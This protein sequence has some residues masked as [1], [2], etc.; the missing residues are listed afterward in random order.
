MSFCDSPS[1]D[2]DRFDR[3]KR[4]TGF[5]HTAIDALWDELPDVADKRVLAVRGFANIVRQHVA[6]QRV[7]A[8]CQL[9]L[10]VM[11]LVRPTYE[12]LVRAVW[13]LNGAENVWI[14]GFFSPKE[15][16]IISDAE[17]RKG[18]DVDAM[19]GTIARHHP[20]HVHAALFGLKDS[21]WRSMHSY[22][23]GGI[24]PVVQ[25]FVS[26]PYQQ[27]ASVL[28]NANGMLLMA[29]NVVRMAHG[30][31]SPML[32]ELQRQYAECLPPVN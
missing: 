30:L 7:L 3:I 20:S 2:V 14:D 16:A 6:S 22:V 5:L 9:D 29:T 26:F 17:T 21:T 23:H 10:S 4:G 28:L 24:R 18:P 13:S 25:S 8:D 11:A 19:L 1:L 31:G 27:V 12:A 32:A 15:A